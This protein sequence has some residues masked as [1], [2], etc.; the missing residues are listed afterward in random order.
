MQVSK[1]EHIRYSGNTLSYS[2]GNTEVVFAA[3]GATSSAKQPS[4]GSRSI[5]ASIPQYQTNPGSIGPRRKRQ[6]LIPA[7]RGPVGIPGSAPPQTYDASADITEMKAQG[8]YQLSLVGCRSPV[9]PRGSAGSARRRR[10]AVGH[11]EESVTD[12]LTAKIDY[13]KIFLHSNLVSLV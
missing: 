2:S 12:S 8:Q 13:S 9:P 4:S 3:G 11:G 1:R 10:E 7:V 6:A 5:L